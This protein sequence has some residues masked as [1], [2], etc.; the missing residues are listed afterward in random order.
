MNTENGNVV[1]ITGASS[2]IGESTATLL[3]REGY[4]VYGSARRTDRM[5]DLQEAGAGIIKIDVTDDASMVKGVDQVMAEQGKIDVLIN[6][7]GYGFFGALEDV[8]L[9]EARRQFEV[10]VFGLGRMTQIVLPHMRKQG[11][12]TIIN[13]SSTGGIITT[14]FGG[15]YQASKFAVEG[16]SDTLRKDV[17]RFGIDVVVI[18]PGAIES[19]WV[20]ITMD[21]LLK[22]SSEPYREAAQKASRAIEDAYKNASDPSVIAR[23]ILKAI[24]AQKPKT[25]YVAGKQGKLILMMH[26]L[27]SDRQFDNMILK[28][29]G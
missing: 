29:I 22:I 28:R 17:K 12:G 2:G 18:E 8:P 4:T 16:L 9:S 6:N 23:V 1:L 13:V 20:S 3:L 25:R 10:N 27:L 15:W 21:H 19:E 14:P 11:S 5:A 26:S 24:K 7:A